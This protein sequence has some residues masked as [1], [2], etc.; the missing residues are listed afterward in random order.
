MIECLKIDP[1]IEILEKNL[2]LCAKNKIFPQVNT[3]ITLYI[4]PLHMGH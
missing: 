4:S 3:L 1:M 2:N